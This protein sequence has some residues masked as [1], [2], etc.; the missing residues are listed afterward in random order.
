MKSELHPEDS[1]F[2][3]TRYNITLKELFLFEARSFVGRSIFQKKPKL[4]NNEKNLLHLGCGNK[5]IENWVNAD[6]FADLKF[7]KIQ[8]NRPDWML[9]LR[10]PLNCEDNVW[11]GVFSE[12]TLEHLYPIDGFNLLKELH[13]TMKPGSWLRITVPD[14][15]KYINY[16]NHK[17]GDRAFLQWS[18]GCEAI[19]ALTQNFGHISVWDVELLGLTL[20]KIG[21]VNVKEVSF[22]QGTVPMLIHDKEDRKWESL[23]MEAQKPQHS[24]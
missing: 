11:D 20:E 24:N 6:F 8:K 7:W 14:L 22:K 19:R 10:Y 16:Y 2:Y 18:T 3:S 23:Y 17:Q 4:K 15:K 13:R 1:G 9:D 12:H 21:F 5:K